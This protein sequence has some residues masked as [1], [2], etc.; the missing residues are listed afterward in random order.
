MTFKIHTNLRRID[1][2][3]SCPE[4]THLASVFAQCMFGSLLNISMIQIVTLCKHLLRQCEVYSVVWRNLKCQL[5]MMTYLMSTG[6]TLQCLLKQNSN[7]LQ[8]EV[9]WSRNSREERKRH[10]ERH[11]LKYYPRHHK[12]KHFVFPRTDGEPAS[13]RDE[14]WRSGDFCTYP[15]FPAIAIPFR[16]Y[17][18]WKLTFHQNDGFNDNEVTHELV[19][20]FPNEN[21]TMKWGGG[22]EMREH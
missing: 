2:D 13:L 15:K 19:F 17:F 8:W 6:H 1:L 11:D 3:I 18:R 20:V 16:K 4:I 10:K 22:K 7:W 5:K 14:D 21:K 9:C 12:E